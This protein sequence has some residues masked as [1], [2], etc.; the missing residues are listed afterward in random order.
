VPSADTLGRLVH[1]LHDE[2]GDPAL[3]RR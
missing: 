2:G 1:A 3:R